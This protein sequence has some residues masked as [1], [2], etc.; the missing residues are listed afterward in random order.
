MSLLL[1]GGGVAQLKTIE[2]ELNNA[3]ARQRAGD[4][5]DLVTQ[6][7]TF[8]GGLDAQKGEIVR[9]HRQHRPAVGHARRAEPGQD[10]GRAGRA[11]EGPEDARRPAPPA[12]RDAHRRCSDLGA[13]GTRVI[14]AS[15][16]RP[17][18]QP[19]GAQ[20]DPAPAQQ[21]RRRPAEDAPA[22]ADLP[23]PGQRADT[24][25]GD[26][27]NL[28]AT[29]DTN[30][31]T[32]AGNLGVGRLP[33]RPGCAAALG[34]TALRSPPTGAGAEAARCRRS[35]CRP[36]PGCRRRRCPV[37]WLG[38]GPSGAG[39]ADA[40]SWS[41]LFP[42]EVPDDHPDRAA[43]ARRLRPAVRH[44]RRH[45]LGQLR[46]AHRQDR[47]RQLRR[48]GRPRAVRRHLRRR[49]GDLPRRHG[50]QGR[51]AAPAQGR[52]RGR[53]Q[54][55]PVA[56]RSRRTPR[57][58]SR[59]A[60]RWGSSTSTSSRAPPGRPVLAAGDVIPRDRHARSRSASTSC[61][62]DVD[63]TVNSVPQDDL[64]TTV[65]RARPGVRRRGRT[66]S[67][68][69]TRRR[70]DHRGHRGAAADDEAHRRRPDRARHPGPERPPTSQIVVRLRR[71]S[72]SPARG[73]PRPARRPRPRGRRRRS[74]S[75]P[76]R[77][78]QAE[79]R[80]APRQLHHRSAT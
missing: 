4:I 36:S 35:R 64:V 24:I 49:R 37:G 72:P 43:P 55:R 52:R 13:V 41:T 40:A 53:R 16:G 7:D 5:K 26:Y 38:S 42:R 6:L 31:G 54:A 15:Q 12:H 56:P 30:L 27:T 18:G 33:E 48:V 69:S 28:W 75:R 50:G 9:A 57:P 63:D 23:V 66:C 1:N 71:T 11:A 3:T 79:P 58:S 21:G 29:L 8:V 80:R 51:G 45:P 59:T 77:G 14:A 34:A 61:S 2:T 76:H 65:G 74:S 20:P 70:P 10:R 60:R 25:K 67:G 32:I 39:S 73:R 68:S 46:R 22:A 62:S 78:Q 19:Q 47:R 17:R 44:P